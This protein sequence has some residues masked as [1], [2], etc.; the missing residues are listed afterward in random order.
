MRR[1]SGIVLTG[2][3]VLALV[4]LLLLSIAG[5]AY[6]WHERDGLIQKEATVTQL[7]RDTKANALACKGSV[8][9]LGTKTEHQKMDIIKALGGAAAGIKQHQE[10]SLA[11]LAATPEDAANLCGSLLK[12]WQS[13]LPLK[14]AQ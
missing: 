11:A 1:Q 2:Y 8:D 9:E 13:R 3:V 14:G 12:F 6:F 7:E 4:I 10:D 5:N